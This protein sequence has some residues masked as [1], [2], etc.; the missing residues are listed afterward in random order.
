[1]E[2]RLHRD[3]CVRISALD[4]Q[5]KQGKS[6]GIFGG[7]Y[8]LSDRATADRVEAEATARRLMA[9]QAA[10]ENANDVTV[11]KLSDRERQVVAGLGGDRNA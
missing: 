4:E 3:D 2:W 8:L 11:W 5:K 9:E 7:G 6:S 10:R 1:M